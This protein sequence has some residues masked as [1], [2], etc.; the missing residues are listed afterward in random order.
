[1]KHSAT[2]SWDCYERRGLHLADVHI[3]FENPLDLEKAREIVLPPLLSSIGETGQVEI[4]EHVVLEDQDTQKI[5]RYWTIEVMGSFMTVEHAKDWQNELVQKLNHLLT[6][7]SFELSFDG[8]S[9][10]R[11]TWKIVK[12]I[13]EGKE[14]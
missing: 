8:P 13:L 10:H 9:S 7:A 1:V 12:R 5:F 6:K 11:E 4:T 3:I 2:L 14:K